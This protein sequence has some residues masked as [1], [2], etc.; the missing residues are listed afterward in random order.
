MEKANLYT[1]IEKT[2]QIKKIM[3][4]IQMIIQKINDY[5]CHQHDIMNSVCLHYEWQK[6]SFLFVAGAS[7][8]AS[9][10]NYDFLNK[11]LKCYHYLS[12]MLY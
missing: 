7:V 3:Q 1:K 5:L 12:D 2:M 11:Q 9:Y 10:A 8:L 6:M 4:I